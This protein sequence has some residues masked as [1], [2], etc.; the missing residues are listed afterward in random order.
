[1][2]SFFEGL[3]LFKQGVMTSARYTVDSPEDLREAKDMVKSEY[4]VIDLMLKLVNETGEC[5]D[6][7]LEPLA[8][9]HTES[10]GYHKSDKEN[11]RQFGYYV[12]YWD[13]MLECLTNKAMTRVFDWDYLYEP[14]APGEGPLSRYIENECFMVLSPTQTSLVDE[15]IVSLVKKSVFSLMLTRQNKLAPMA[16]IADE[17]Q[18]FISADSHTGEHNFV[19]RCRSYRVNCVFITQSLAHLKNK[20]IEKRGQA[21]DQA[22]EAMLNN[23][24]N[25]IVFRSTDAQTMQLLRTWIPCPPVMNSRHVIDV[26][27]PSGL[28]VGECYFI[29]ARGE[30]GRQQVVLPQD[31]PPLMPRAQQDQLNLHH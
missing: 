23:M 25:R 27:P 10:I 6:E 12:S 29:T 1:E 16:Y 11:L 7:L 30:W 21:G 19:D 20:V 24:T 28:K 2:P 15:L 4:S 14:S 17:F 22:L 5:F 13:L 3:K 18:N 8:I 9:Y 26:R 31:W